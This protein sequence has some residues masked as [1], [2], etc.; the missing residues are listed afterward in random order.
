MCIAGSRANNTILINDMDFVSTI[1]IGDE[2]TVSKTASS[3][4]KTGLDT[5]LRG[6]EE[7]LAR[8]GMENGFTVLETS[9]APT[10]NVSRDEQGILDIALTSTST[11]AQCGSYSSSLDEKLTEP[12]DQ[13]SLK[14]SQK[15]KLS[16]SVTWADEKTDCVGG[17]QLCEIREIED[18]MEDL[19]VV[20][21][22]N[23]VSFKS[24]GTMEVGQS[25][26]D[27]KKSK[28][29]CEVREMED[30]K[31]ASDMLCSMDIGENDDML[32]F[33][34]A[35][36]CARALDEASEAVASQEFEVNNASML[37]FGLSLL[38]VCY[39]GFCVS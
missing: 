14:P 8:K 2:Y 38:I 9:Y 23:K 31:E 1:V 37:L 15:K 5:K 7:N 3:S 34:S 24:S 4:K 18:M 20:A 33:A 35:E 6:Q 17:R 19:S 25:V 22:D 13:S 10:R 16:R 27:G 12:S 32:R 30:A 28:D 11:S 36:A 39:V 26:T 21:N 29:V